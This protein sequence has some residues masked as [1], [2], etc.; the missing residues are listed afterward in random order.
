MRSQIAWVS[1]KEQFAWF[2]NS[3]LLSWEFILGVKELKCLVK[4]FIL[5]KVKS[6]WKENREMCE[7]LNQKKSTEKVFE[8]WWH[9]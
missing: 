6:Y 3:T 7:L 8:D 5:S 2:A 9:A 4:S 1:S